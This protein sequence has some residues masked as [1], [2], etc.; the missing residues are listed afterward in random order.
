MSLP[1]IKLR[2]D[3]ERRL[4]AGHLWIYS[5]EVDTAATPLRE[6]SPGDPVAIHSQRG[7]W[8]GNGYV[9]P[10]S[11]ICA[12]VLSEDPRERLD[13]G[14]L[15]KRLADALALRERRY[16]QPFYRL[17]FGE[18]DRLPGLV[19]DRYGDY[20]AV[21]ITTAGMERLK[22]EI[23]QVLSELLN[24]LGI[25]LRN[26]S[27]V[28]EFE[29]LDLYVEVAAGNVPDDVA[30]EEGGCRFEV[31]LSGG[32]KTGWFYDQAANRERMATYVAG[33][34]ALDVCSYVGGWG[35]RAAVAGAK[36]VT[37]VDASQDALVRVNSNA[38]L[39]G[40]EDRV[41]TSSG[42]AF[43]VLRALRQQGER[44]DVILLDPPAFIKRKKDLTE[45][46]LAYRRLNQTA[47]EVLA[48]EGLLITSSCSFHMDR[49]RLLHT[50]Q[51]A[52]RRAG[53]FLRLLEYGQQAPD[54]PV[55]PAIDETAY[56]KTLFLWSAP[57]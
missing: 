32:Q 25:V 29:H 7:R 36:H 4:R 12:R 30:I 53:R 9:N 46:T 52:G 5:N 10:H 54:H 31:S 35:V 44:F 49:G 18:S 20:L 11:L 55:H 22:D 37:C 13:A 1:T 40:V 41:S 26:D 50:V 3:Q 42:D 14:F 34:R 51:Q 28:R 15:R 56:L 27:A 21:Q 47:L 16:A 17:A 23:L 48:D 6:F 19:V 38:A 45:G 57:I 24:P 2:K 43:E 39:N 8:L 33:K